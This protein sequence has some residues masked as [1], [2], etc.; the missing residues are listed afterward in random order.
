MSQSKY[1]NMHKNVYWI[2]VKVRLPKRPA[3]L[4]L[5]FEDGEIDIFRF[6]PFFGLPERT[7][8]WSFLPE[9]YTGCSDAK[10]R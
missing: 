10:N 2:P 1:Y 5:C 8:A 4:L 9:P 6:T 3:K 7:V